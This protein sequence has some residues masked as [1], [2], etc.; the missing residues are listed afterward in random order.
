MARIQGIDCESIGLVIKNSEK[1]QEIRIFPQGIEPPVRNLRDGVVYFGCKRKD[2]QGNT[3]VDYVCNLS[4]KSLSDKYRGP[5]FMIY[6]DLSEKAY[7]LHDL[8]LGFGS[9]LRIT[10]TLVL[11]DDFLLSI[12]ESFM[13][14]NLIHKTQCDMYPRLRVKLFGGQCP[15]EIFYFHPQEFYLCNI[16]VGRSQKCQV[17][18]HDTLISKQH[19]SIF[20]TS[21]RNWV[22]IDGTA[23]TNSTNGTWLYINH[24][25]KLANGMEFKACESIFKVIN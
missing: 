23:T 7:F 25:I 4:N 18:V 16:V 21:D 11:E 13:L 15:E 2:L 19:A 3:V 8:A 9:F 24:D 20:F 14:V 10:E 12:G 5:H 6:F 17:T 1:F 22:I